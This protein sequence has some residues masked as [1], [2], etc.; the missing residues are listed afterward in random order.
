MS[1][2]GIADTTDRLSDLINGFQATQAIHVAVTLG[3]P[4][5]L[6]NGPR[7]ID[8]LA[9]LTATHAG[10]LYRLLRALAAI[11]LLHER[12]LLQFS[13]TPLGEGL[14]AGG[15]GSRNAWS[16][17]IATPPLWAAWGNLLHSVRTGETGF[18]H[19]HG[20]DVWAFRAANPKDAALFDLAMREASKGIA[21]QVL[22]AY[23]FAQF[24]HIVDVGGGDGALIAAILARCPHTTGTLLD[25]AH[26]VAR[27]GDVLHQAA[28]R[29]RC[30]VLAGSFFDGVP[31]GADAYVLKSILHD[32]DDEGAQRI[33]RHCRASMH[34]GA[35]LLI[36]E[37]ILAPPDEGA[38]AKLSD[39]NM[40]VN[41]GGR[42]RTRE[43]FAAILAAAGLALHASTP[44]SRSRCVLEAMVDPRP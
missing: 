8:D 20:Q 38:E 30:E 39:L 3:V 40:L 32:W 13:L 33:L 27:A 41:A 35:R 5:L 11:G 2:P 16:R 28:V 44:L 7:A 1:P 17:F 36:I 10:S 42:E 4:D 9:S 25:L 23:D 26:V 15:E 24:G 43:E 18:R 22:G 12:E 29:D 14:V 31:A 34:S 6:R 21:Q 19:V 37:R